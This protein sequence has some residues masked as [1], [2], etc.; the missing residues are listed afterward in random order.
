M[1][2]EELQKLIGD[3]VTAFEHKDLDRIAVI[4][5]P[6]K[7]PKMDKELKEILLQIRREVEKI[8]PEPRRKTEG[9]QA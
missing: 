4:N 3:C 2:R 7:K 1:T 5:T 6:A 9:W 8:L